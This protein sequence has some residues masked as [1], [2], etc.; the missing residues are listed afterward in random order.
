MPEFKYVAKDSA[1][2][3]ATGVLEADNEMELRYLLRANDLFLTK[4]GGPGT[5]IDNS[6]TVKPSPSWSPWSK[7][8]LQDLT[9][10]TRQLSSLMHAGLSLPE[11]LDIVK[12]QS[13][14]PALQNAFE[15][16][17]RG[18]VA[19]R[20]LSSVMRQHPKLFNAL[21]VALVEAGEATGALDEAL[22]VIAEQYDKEAVLKRRIKLAMAYP[23]IVVLAAVGSV[24]GML[25]FVVPVFSKVYAQFKGVLPGPTRMLIA[26]SDLLTNYWWLGILI[27]PL[28]A[29]GFKHFQQTEEGRRWLDH[30]VLQLPLFGP[31]IRK[32]VIARFVHTL[33]N[34]LR[35]GVPVLSSLL[36]AASTAGNK[37]IEDAVVAAAQNVRDGSSMAHELTKTGEFPMMVTRMI[38]AGEASGNVDHMLEEINRFYERDVSYAVETMTRMMEPLMT[39]VLGTVVCLI[40]VAMYMPIF[41]LAQVIR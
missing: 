3:A 8:N 15:D 38:A 28:G 4:V 13:T 24:S 34:G 23:K 30:K 5:L 26:L 21:A 36:V 6:E 37:R 7:P 32:L 40:L 41:N 9:I 18:V 35:G 22:E 12:S 16:M 27:I 29:L 11:S 10:A 39:I 20:S 17:T 2:R 25:M 33:S 19:G 1:G 14:K 31:L